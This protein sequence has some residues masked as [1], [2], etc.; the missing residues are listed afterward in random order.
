MASV[1]R[2]MA[3]VARRG[4]MGW[5]ATAQTLPAL[6]RRSYSSVGGVDHQHTRTAR[7]DELTSHSRPGVPTPSNDLQAELAAFSARIGVQFVNDTT[8]LEAITFHSRNRQFNNL[9]LAVL[10]Q[11]TLQQWATEYCFVHYPRLPKAALVDLQTHAISDSTAAKAAARV[12]LQHVLQTKPKTLAETDRCQADGL[13][14]MVGAVLLDQGSVAARQFCRTV[15]QEELAS[16]D[17][18]QFVRLAHP[19]LL[20]SHLLKAQQR[21]APEMRVLDESGRLTHLPTFRVG[22]F[23]GDTM[24]GEGTSYSIKKAEA[25]AAQDALLSQFGDELA[26]SPLPSDLDDYRPEDQIN[27]RA[28]PSE[29]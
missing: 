15:L 16:L 18:G 22:V 10:G 3:S 29:E 14:A 20:L 17:V 28:T 9:R 5:T 4:V 13:R 1:A 26:S 6:C 2:V 19:K 23:A 21:P 8:L 11:S 27:L 24:L 12:G 25:A 7:V